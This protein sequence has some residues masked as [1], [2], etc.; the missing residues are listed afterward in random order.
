MV[1]IEGRNAICVR[2]KEITE[3]VIEYSSSSPSTESSGGGG[4]S[5]ESL[6]SRLD[7]FSD[8]CAFSAFKDMSTELVFFQVA[9]EVHNVSP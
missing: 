8:V 5:E 4:G 3:L 6:E 7:R 9:A 2:F 1:A